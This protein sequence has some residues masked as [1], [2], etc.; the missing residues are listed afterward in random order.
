MEAGEQKQK[1]PALMLSQGEYSTAVPAD[2]A[3]W[4]IHTLK[5]FVGHI[6]SEL[7]PWM[8][9]GPTPLTVVVEPRTDAHGWAWAAYYGRTPDD[10]DPP[11]TSGLVRT[12]ISVYGDDSDVEIFLHL[13][14]AFAQE[15][16]EYGAWQAEQLSPM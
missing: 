2:S 13:A 11:I 7:R 9:D 10:F 15:F 1:P 6:M 12:C 14:L 3:L 4:M 8:N 16:L 5:G